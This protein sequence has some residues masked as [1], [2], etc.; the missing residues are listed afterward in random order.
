MEYQR[1]LKDPRTLRVFFSSPFGGMEDER[2]E[3]TRKYFPQI[4]HFCN[5]KGLL[6]HIIFDKNNDIKRFK[7]F[8]Y[9]VLR[10]HIHIIIMVYQID[11]MLARR[12]EQYY[13]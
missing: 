13:N 5:A 11:F 4:H 7:M 2:E 1:K 12:S 8:I 6:S 10:Y 3:L 9:R